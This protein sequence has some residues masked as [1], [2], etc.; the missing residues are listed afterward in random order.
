M[1]VTMMLADAVQAADG[2]L[3]ILG[4]GWSVTGPTATPGAIAMMI[5]VPWDLANQRH[6][7]RLELEDQDGRPV[8]LETEGGTQDGIVIAGEF[9]VG[10]PPGLRPGTP[11][12]VP[13]AINYGPIPFPPGQRFV[14][15]LTLNDLSQ[16]DWYLAFATRPAP[17]QA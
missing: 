12:D 1:K 14:W 11:L 17:D 4:G 10:R 6:T 7:W 3:F 15:R 8:Q 9:E 16:D 13:L 2:K 5:E